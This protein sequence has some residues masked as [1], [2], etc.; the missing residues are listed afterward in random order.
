MNRSRHVSRQLEELRQ[1]ELTKESQ[2][3]LWLTWTYALLALVTRRTYGAVRAVTRHE[4][5][6]VFILALVFFGGLRFMPAVGVRIARLLQS[7]AGYGTCDFWMDS[8]A[9][10][11][12]D[13]SLGMSMI[14]QRMSMLM[15][16]TAATY[17][18][19]PPR[20]SSR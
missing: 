6:F 4:L 11:G 2:R 16:G 3:L 13:G 17:D 5:A 12:G 10:G 18:C 20:S 14:W 19:K 8:A 7:E 1:Q 9:A 15:Y